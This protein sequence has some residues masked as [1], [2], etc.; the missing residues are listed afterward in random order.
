M[1]KHYPFFSKKYPAKSTRAIA[2]KAL[3]KV[4]KI[5]KNIEVKYF[6]SVSGITVDNDGNVVHL[7]GIAQN[8]LVDG[9][10]GNQVTVTKIE[11]RYT[12]DIDP[13][14]LSISFRII[15]LQDTQQVTD[16]APA[17]LDI[18]QVSTP[19]A[20]INRPRMKRFKILKQRLFT[21]SNSGKTMQAFTW[22]IKTNINVR[23]NGTGA[24][25]IQRNNLYMCLISDEAVS[26]PTYVH[27]VRLHYT[28]T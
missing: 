3:R 10:T 17:V 7:T 22:I 24:G 23:W 27:H 12:I 28:D 11:G 15:L 9:R 13:T 25:D 2:K 20:P 1:P 26:P 19:V 16:V 21:L 5:N 14:D 6:D 8:D 18:M 4:N